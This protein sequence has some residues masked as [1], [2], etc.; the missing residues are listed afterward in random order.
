M[1]NRVKPKLLLSLTK[2]IF[3]LVSTLEKTSCTSSEFHK[4]LLQWTLG[5]RNS[6]LSSDNNQSSPT[7]FTEV[8]DLHSFDC[9]TNRKIIEL[10][11]C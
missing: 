4:M 10:G 1:T 2:M 9:E 7:K 8:E 3:N 6:H 11:I 5:L